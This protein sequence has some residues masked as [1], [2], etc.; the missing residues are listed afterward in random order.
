MKYTKEEIISDVLEGKPLIITDDADRENEGDFFVAA[1]RASKESILL[2][3]NEGRGLICTP[4][5]KEVAHKLDLH[6]MVD[7]NSSSHS[8]AF[9]VSVDHKSNSTGISLYDRLITINKLADKESRPADFSRRGHIF[10]LISVD[11]GLK[12]RRGHTE[13]SIDLCKQ[14]GLEEVGVI[15]EILNDDGSIAKTDDLERLS[16]KYN[17]KMVSIEE[18]IQI[19]NLDHIET[20]LPTKYGD[21]TMF[22]FNEGED[23]FSVLGTKRDKDK[24]PMVR[25]HSEC[26][27]G[28]VFGSLRCDCGEQL[29]K[30][31]EKISDYG[32]GF[33]IYLKQEGRG[34]GLENKLSAYNLQDAGLDTF[35]ANAKL[36]FKD[37]LRDYKQALKF[38]NNFNISKLKLISNNPDKIKFLINNGI[39]VIERID[40]NILPNQ[41]NRKYFMAKKNK[42]NHFL[43]T[44]VLNERSL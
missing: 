36:G 16:K 12:K 19:F 33:L 15:C 28:D 29:S 22:H 39:E 14:S 5:S 35:E 24:I 4:M 40:L 27:T 13:A 30:S 32:H 8:T 42:K 7:N 6:P 38:L 31:L 37:D 17:L 21:F 23:S 43:N 20:T 26:F 44:E 2:M 34:I 10:P 3:L 25:I 41:K 1:S 18:I 9:T 11:G